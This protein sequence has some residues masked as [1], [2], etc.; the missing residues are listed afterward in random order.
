MLE[1]GYSRETFH[2]PV[3][4]NERIEQDISDKYAS[5]KTVITAALIPLIA[6]VPLIYKTLKDSYTTTTIPVTSTV[7]APPPLIAPPPVLPVS[8]AFT[9][10]STPIP[11]PPS[12]IL[13][14]PTGLIA[15]TSLEMLANVLDPL[16]Q[17]MVAISLP[18]ASVIMI[19]GCF[20]FMIGN[21]EKAW[22]T[23][24]NGS[25][26]YILVQMSPLFIKILRQV[27]EAV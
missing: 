22:S 27:G 3:R 26:G 12:D 25:L 1:E 2:L 13:A 21:S 5:K 6:T 7:I 18:I 9:S 20:F 16:I 8:E 15:D 14:E 10:L 17:L 4:H 11:T 24:M 19:G 23:I